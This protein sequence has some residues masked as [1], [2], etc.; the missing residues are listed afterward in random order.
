MPHQRR[1]RSA[2]THLLFA[3]VLTTPLVIASCER[4]AN[5]SSA[6]RLARMDIPAHGYVDPQAVGSYPSSKQR[7]QGWINAGQTDSIRAHGW[8]IWQS[9][10]TMVNDSTP[11][12]QT[13]YSG[14]ELFDSLATPS[15]TQRPQSMRLPIERP[16]QFRHSLLLAR[17]R[18]LRAAF[19]G[20]PVDTAERVFAFNR[21]SRSTATYIWN[22]QLNRAQTLLAQ[23]LG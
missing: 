12:W 20:I 18:G 19:A 1:A 14:H 3:L 2:R 16:K 21:F 9:I 11:T 22:N 4:A 10:T 23:G 15:A 5:R 7:I 8:D 13:W 17:N 6:S